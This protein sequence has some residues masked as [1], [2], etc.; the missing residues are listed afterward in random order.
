MHTPLLNHNQVYQKVPVSWLVPHK[1]R[2]PVE[3]KT[4]FHEILTV[5]SCQILTCFCGHPVFSRKTILMSFHSIFHLSLL[6]NTCLFS[7]NMLITCYSAKGLVLSCARQLWQLRPFLDDPKVK[8]LF[9]IML[10]VRQKLI[11]HKRILKYCCCSL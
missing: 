9:T 5:P 11:M 7:W 3:L 4:G 10:S 6:N 1:T 8:N 2:G